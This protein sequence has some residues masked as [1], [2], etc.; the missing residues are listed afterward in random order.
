LGAAVGEVARRASGGFKDPLLGR[1]AA[2]AAAAGILWPLV[3]LILTRADYLQT[4]GT[5]VV[6][7]VLGG[8]IAGYSA[9]QRSA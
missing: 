1:G 7:W 8:I 2:I 9:W 4:H 6:F 3:G 5:S